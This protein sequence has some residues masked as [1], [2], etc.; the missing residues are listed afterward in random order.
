MK[1]N[2]LCVMCLA[3]SLVWLPAEAGIAAGRSAEDQ[4]LEGGDLL[5]PDLDVFPESNT[6]LP[7]GFTLLYAYATTTDHKFLNIQGETLLD[8]GEAPGWSPSLQIRITDDEGNELGTGALTSLV[9][10]TLPDERMPFTGGAELPTVDFD[11]VGWSDG[12]H[13]LIQP[14]T[15][16][17]NFDPLSSRSLSFKLNDIS[18]NGVGIA[19]DGS[20]TNES[21][22][23]LDSVGIE[24]ALYREDGIYLGGFSYRESSSGS[25]NPGRFAVA[26][27]SVSYDSSAGPLLGLTADDV[28]LVITPQV[29]SNGFGVC[30]DEFELETL[31]VDSVEDLPLKD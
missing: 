10:A 17:Y 31:Y 6:E 7:N 26:S 8:D 15:Y 1:T 5:L 3:L 2:L 27:G 13:V 22:I 29:T 20:V 30:G 9:D 16:E 25:L 14:C 23:S 24:G 4:V 11:E 18:N 28:S 19:Y 21:G 12:L